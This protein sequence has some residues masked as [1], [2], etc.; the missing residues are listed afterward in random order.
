METLQ[1]QLTEALRQ[2]DALERFQPQLQNEQH[3]RMASVEQ[4]LAVAEA[5]RDEMVDQM[6]HMANGIAIAEVMHRQVHHAIHELRKNFEAT[7]TRP[8]NSGDGG[9]LVD[10][11]SM[12][13]AVYTGLGSEQEW[14]IWSVKV[15]QYVATKMKDLAT[16]MHIVGKL[17]DSL[18]DVSLNQFT[19]PADADLQ[20][21][22]FLTIRTEIAPSEIVQ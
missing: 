14:R 16:A 18:D 15:R 17:R 3:Q 2:I 4:R 10:P 7:R 12:I 21:I 6:A 13:P 20:L 11:K 1:Q 9:S 5:N 19:I 22:W 8:H